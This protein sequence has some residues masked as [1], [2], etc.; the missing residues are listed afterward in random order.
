MGRGIQKSQKSKP[1]SSKQ[2]L[3]SSPRNSASL[4]EQ[5]KEKDKLKKVLAD[6]QPPDST[7][8]IGNKFWK[9]DKGLFHRD[10]DLPA[11][12]KWDGQK[13]WYQ[14]GRLHRDGGPAIIHGSGGE[15]WFQDDLL[16]RGG[17]LP[18][19]EIDGRKEWWK[20]NLRHRDGDKPAVVNP[21]GT[22]E[23][24]RNGER[25]RDDDKP[26]IVYPDGSEEYWKQGSRYNILAELKV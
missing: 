5:Q 20:N 21:D 14:H 24:W 11:V 25:H 9:D 3:F 2:V 18:A 15:K 1:L 7:D 10:N 22:L 4:E 19:I 12:I 8:E 6:S 13:E 26:A 16:H 23:W 17:D